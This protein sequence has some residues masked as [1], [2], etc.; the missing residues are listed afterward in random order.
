MDS[1]Y[2]VL[3]T[4]RDVDDGHVY[5]QHD[6]EHPLQ[7]TAGKQQLFP[8]IEALLDTMK[9]GQR[10][11]V[12]LGPEDAFGTHNDEA[13]VVVPLDSLPA[14][15]RY[16]GATVSLELTPDQEVP[17]TVADVSSEMATI[18]FN[19]PLAGKDISVEVYLVNRESV[20]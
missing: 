5:F 4:I 20:Q 10:Q 17:G 3:I 2:T 9:I 16:T 15:L 11:V 18:D 1:I 6:P 12:R 13:C 19:H 14:D 7:L 8:K